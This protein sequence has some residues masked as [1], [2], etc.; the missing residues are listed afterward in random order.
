MKVKS[1]TPAWFEPVFFILILGILVALSFNYHK[2]NG[3]FNWKSEIWADRAAYYIFM[4]ATFY[5]HWDI[6]QCPPKMDE[7]TGYG[8]VYDQYHHKIKTPVSCGPAILISPFFVGVHFYTKIAGVPQDWGFAPAYHNMVNVAAV[9]YLV[10]GLFFLYRFLGKYFSKLT[11]FLTVV[12]LLAGTNL[13]FYSTVDTLMPH[14][15][16]FFLSSAFLLFLKKHL[17]EPSKY[18]YFLLSGLALALA[19]LIQPL[20]LLLVLLYFML[21]ILSLDE[22]KARSGAFFQLKHLPVLVLII[23]IVYLPQAMYNHYAS[24][25]Y[26]VFSPDDSWSNILAPRLPQLW[27][28]TLNG[29]FLYSPLMLLIIA[30][31]AMMMRRKAANAWIALIFFLLISYLLAAHTCWYSGCSYGQRT[32]V[33]FLPLFAI[34]FTFLTEDV[35]GKKRKPVMVSIV[36]LLLFFSWYNFRLTRAYEECFFGS[37]WDW[38]KYA[39]MLNKAHLLPVKPAYAYTNDYENTAINNGSVITGLVSRSGNNSLLFD[40]EHEFNSYFSEYPAMLGKD[41]AVRK[42]KI[43]FYIFNTS[44]SPTGALV[45]CDISSKGQRIYYESRPA[46]APSYS[47]RQWSTVPVNFDIPK[48]I[49]PWAELKVYIWNRNKSTFYVDDFEIK[50]E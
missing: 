35:I 50:T 21:D 9:F 25:Q 44:P 23:I 47:A 6:K 30:G 29:L 5:Y 28:S 16:S 17:D 48:T 7:R 4:P 8:F 46:D 24:G 31:M 39:L 22:L 38:N 41:S 49:D 37:T 43:K 20:S 1:K 11:S 27:F 32:F 34:P 12:F 40:R 33:D 3:Y 42:L 2:K 10:L 26:L 19:V 15:Y 18:L 14:V 13:F 36:I 45:I